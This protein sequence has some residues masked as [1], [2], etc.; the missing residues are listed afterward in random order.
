MPAP[1][2]P[3]RV[4]GRLLALAALLV[5]AAGPPAAAQVA[6]AAPAAVRDA[7]RLVVLLVVDQC[8]P[9]YLFRPELAGG[10][11]DTL[12][13][14]G[15]WFPDAAH[16]HTITF[17]A[18][19]H[20]AIATGCLP[21]RAGIAGNEW[22][23]RARHA[24]VTSVED[25]AAPLVG[26][27]LRPG[28]PGASAAR[29]RRPTLGDVLVAE[30]GEAAHVISVGW[31]DRSAILLGGRH[32]DGSYW[33]DPVSGR[34]V[35]SRAFRPTLPVFLRAL[36]GDPVR[37]C[38][39]QTWTRRGSDERVDDA[40]GERPPSG[41]GT[42]FPHALP[43][44]PE[45]GADLTRL[46]ELVACTPWADAAVAHAAC[47]ELGYDVPELGQDDAPDLL[48]VAFA[49][50]D[51]AGHHFGPESCEVAEVLRALDEQV[52]LL[53]A[54]LDE[55]VG[56]GRWTLALT[57]DHGVQPVP[58]Q[59]GGRRLDG[60]AELKTLEQALVARFGDPPPRPGEKRPRWIAAALRPSI[61]LD[62]ERVAA[63][64]L[65]L[66]DVARETAARLAELPG[67]D[68]A[69]TQADL[70]ALAAREASDRP[71]A[72]EADLL[73]LARDVVPELSGDV[74]FLLEPNVLL[75]EDVAATHGTQHAD[76]RQV[77]LLFFGAGIRPG[78]YPGPA[79][80]IDIAPTLARLLG[81]KG[82][83]DADGRVLEQ[84]L[85]PAR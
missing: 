85:S 28:S 66:E 82:L 6:P 74:L 77:P 30:R 81:L 11:L 53:V 34:W 79:A 62:R 83:S 4:P 41:L 23:D 76:D 21:A 72:P 70:T 7:P 14:G 40:A 52:G 31:K 1:T 24:L 35:T 5:A 46:E 19:G 36:C 37:G 75:G 78:T 10:T 55:R 51:F 25:E 12:R 9:E 17:T 54:Q 65:Q 57:A 56:R 3:S 44:A 15:A 32:S 13:S 33:I 27:G 2:F 67:V 71:Q 68:R 69:A 16:T 18:P 50:L 49:S 84:A 8:R 43:R 73:A 61:W 39:G 80:P 45:P 22:Y 20:A 59:S 58:E 48:C 64:G 38:A 47:V 42:T 26:E 29:L 60:V 63:A